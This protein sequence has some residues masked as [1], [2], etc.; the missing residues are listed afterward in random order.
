MGSVVFKNVTMD[1]PGSYTIDNQTFSRRELLLY[2]EEV[3][4][5]PEAEPWRADVFRFILDLFDEKQ[6]LYQ[7]TSGTTGDPKKILLKRSAMLRSA[8]NTLQYFDLK[9]GDRTLLCLPVQY[10]AGKMMVVR[11]L[12]GGLH[13]LTTEPSGH[14]LTGL[15]S[16]IDFAAMV[17]LQLHETLKDDRSNALQQIRKLLIGGGE[18]SPD[19]RSQLRII[20]NVAIYETFGMSE[21]YTHFAVKR[22]NGTLPGTTFNTLPGVKITTDERTCLVVEIPGVTDGPV[23]TNDMVEITAEGAFAWQGRIDHLI[24]SGGVKINPEILEKQIGELTGREV[25]VLGL[26]D[27][28]LGQKLVLV[29]EEAVEIS[30]TTLST[31]LKNYEIPKE[32]ITIPRFPRNRSMKIDRIAVR[33]RLISEV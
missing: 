29:V 6:P 8:R 20:K 15:S 11:A 7:E 10:I 18:I 32:I 28:K 5:S 2:A 17:P 23:I 22:L 4:E 3:A 1:M 13:L 31:V 12:A 26:P 14:P 27:K 33:K 9:P 16:P 25:L 21:T 19:L 24:K 30:K